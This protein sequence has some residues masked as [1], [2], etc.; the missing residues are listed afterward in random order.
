MK[1][2][3]KYYDDNLKEI[4]KLDDELSHVDPN[5]PTDREKI[6]YIQTS[7]KQLKCV[8]FINGSIINNQFE[9]EKMSNLARFS[10]VKKTMIPNIFQIYMFLVNVVLLIIMVNY[11]L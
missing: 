11:N 10:A 1:S 2:G 4:N 8:R 3:K 5:N 7:K 6:V 9:E